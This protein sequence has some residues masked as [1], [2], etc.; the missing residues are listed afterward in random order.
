MP[1][2]LHCASYDDLDYFLCSSFV[3]ATDTDYRHVHSLVGLVFAGFFFVSV[4]TLN[5]LP[6]GFSIALSAQLCDG[7]FVL[8]GRLEQCLR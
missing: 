2:F 3:V 5:S 1:C 8:L 7:I 6:P 4:L